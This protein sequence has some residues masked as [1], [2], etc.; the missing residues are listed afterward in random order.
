MR[1][2]DPEFVAKA[3]DVVGLYRG[4]LKNAVPW[5]MRLRMKFSA[6]L[7]EG[8]TAGSVCRHARG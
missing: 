4:R 2:N 7:S 3:A 8:R 5:A 6:A 1:D